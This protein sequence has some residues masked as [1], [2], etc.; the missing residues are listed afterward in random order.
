MTSLNNNINQEKEVDEFYKILNNPQCSIQNAIIEAG[1]KY[2][3]LII[4]VN[5]VKDENRTLT[6]KVNTLTK[7]VETLEDKETRRELLLKSSQLC[8]IIDECFK[9]YM[10]GVGRFG[11][12]KKGYRDK[13]NYMNDYEEKVTLGKLNSLK[14][15]GKLYNNE[16]YK[17]NKCLKQYKITNKIK[18]LYYFIKKRR[19]GVSHPYVDRTD[20]DDIDALLKTYKKKYT[21]EFMNV[22]RQINIEDYQD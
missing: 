6:K 3:K 10:F 7:K 5:D 22:I 18:N 17:F 13:E 20:L 16:E 9:E 15:Q 2:E 4:H 14:D 11:K 19:G 21:P 8:T 1:N 12:I